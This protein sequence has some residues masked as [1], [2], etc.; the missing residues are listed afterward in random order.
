MG[1][2]PI[3]LMGDELIAEL[4]RSTGTAAA[5]AREDGKS[6]GGAPG[7]DPDGE[8]PGVDP[9]GEAPPGYRPRH[10][11]RDAP[12]NVDDPVAGQPAGAAG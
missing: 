4:A 1:A 11:R 7:V 5:V 6:G 2:P 9:D 3:S 8:A 10:A 12:S